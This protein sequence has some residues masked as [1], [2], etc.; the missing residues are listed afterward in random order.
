MPPFLQFRMWLREGPTAERVLAGLAGVIVL[1]LVVVA[2]VPVSSDDEADTLATGGAPAG[3][4]EGGADGASDAVPGT[5]TGP[6][7]PGATTAT[8]AGASTSGGTGATTAGGSTAASGTAA[9]ACAALGASAPGVTAKEIRLDVSV[10]SLAGPI[11]NSTFDIRTDLHEIADALTDEINRTG[12][13]ACGRKVVIKQYDVNPLD[14]NDSQTKCLQMVQDNPFLVIDFGGYLRTA[15]RR[16]FV[17]AKL[18]IIAALAIDEVEAKSAFPYVLSP[19]NLAEQQVRNGI[20]GLRDHGFFAGPEFRKIGLFED[21]CLPSVHRDIDRALAEA[22]VKPNQVSKF[23]LA[24]EVAAPPNQIAQAVLQHKGDNVSH[25][26]LASSGTNAQNYVRIATSQGL[27]PVYGASDYG[28]VTTGAG[29]GNWGAP[30][31]GATAITSQHFGEVNSGIRNPELQACDQVARRHG[32]RGFEDEKE[33]VGLASFC[34]VFQYFK[35]AINKAGENPTRSSFVQGISAL[36]TFKTALLGDGVFDRP[37]KLSGGDFQRAI[38]Y[39]GDCTCWKLVDRD[40]K[41]AFR[42]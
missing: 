9:R 16:C 13:V 21:A 35:A 17:E 31:D 26:F 37:G 25:V 30:F 5:P 1:A 6:A 3:A 38:R 34:D 12:G 42:R 15:A 28:E 19:R 14:A 32:L 4:T 8:T 36:G 41:P 29:S 10:V 39:H 33:D 40:F 27:N 23:V 11:G 7:E 20:L 24:C 18:P 2:L 22:G